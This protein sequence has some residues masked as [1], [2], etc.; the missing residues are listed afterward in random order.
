MTAVAYHAVMS[1][2][3]SAKSGKGDYRD[4]F[5]QSASAALRRFRERDNPTGQKLGNKACGEMLGTSEA[6]ISKVCSGK[7]H[8]QMDLA[9]ALAEALGVSVDDVLRRQGYPMAQPDQVSRVTQAK[10]ARR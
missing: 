1:S 5:A 9:I 4:D 2:G 7:Q 3:E 6:T 10:R 8:M